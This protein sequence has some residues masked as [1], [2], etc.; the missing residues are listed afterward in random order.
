MRRKYLLCADKLQRVASIKIGT[1]DGKYGSVR[2]EREQNQSTHLAK[3][4]ND[5]NN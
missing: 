4:M 2:R 1:F 5:M 3:L